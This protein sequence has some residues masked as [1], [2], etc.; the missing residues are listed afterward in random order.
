MFFVQSNCDIFF[1]FRNS[2]PSR[3]NNKKGI[4]FNDCNKKKNLREKKQQQRERERERERERK[5]FYEMI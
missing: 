5:D 4:T 1:H 3:N 2:I